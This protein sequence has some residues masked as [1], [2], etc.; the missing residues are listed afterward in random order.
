MGSLT[1]FAELELSGPSFQR[2]LYTG[3]HAVSVAGYR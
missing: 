3:R 1:N 2:G